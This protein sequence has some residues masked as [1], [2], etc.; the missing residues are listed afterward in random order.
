[1]KLITLTT[2]S[3]C[4]EQYRYIDVEYRPRKTEKYGV[5]VFSKQPH[6]LVSFSDRNGLRA[7]HKY[8]SQITGNSSKKCQEPEG[9]VFDT[10][11]QARE[12]H[13]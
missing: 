5:L 2:K 11:H 12:A 4:N 10:L 9:N 13:K 6:Y 3:F 1:M 8:F 7:R